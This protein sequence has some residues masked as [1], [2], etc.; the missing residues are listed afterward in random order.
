MNIIDKYHAIML[1]TINNTNKKII[2]IKNDF[3]N[4]MFIVINKYYLLYK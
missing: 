1:I 4:Y 3:F 2:D